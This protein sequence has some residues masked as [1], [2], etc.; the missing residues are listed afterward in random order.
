MVEA[1]IV[2]IYLSL[3]LSLM[4]NPFGDRQRII[5]FDAEMSSAPPKR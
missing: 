3:S 5:D 2:Q 4:L 1:G